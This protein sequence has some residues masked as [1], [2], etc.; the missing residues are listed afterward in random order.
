MFYASTSS[1]FVFGPPV[2]G[3]LTV[4]ADVRLPFLVLGVLVAASSL[5]LRDAS[6]MRRGEPR[7]RPIRA[8]TG[9]CCD[10]C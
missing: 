6:S 9:G 1:G 10:A 8:P 3:L 2:A 4:I 5:A 7:G